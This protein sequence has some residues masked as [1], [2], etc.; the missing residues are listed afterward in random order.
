MKSRMVRVRYQRDEISTAKIMPHACDLS[1]S[2]DWLRVDAQES[3]DLHSQ[4]FFYL[5][6][7]VLCNQV[8]IL[9]LALGKIVRFAKMRAHYP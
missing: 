7:E 6:H 2:G 5:C 8:K 3:Q 4:V 9:Q 1:W